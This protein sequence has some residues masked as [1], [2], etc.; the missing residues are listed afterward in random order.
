MSHRDRSRHGHSLIAK[1][2]DEIEGLARADATCGR[3]MTV[4]GIGPIIASAMVAATG[5]GAAFERARLCRMAWSSTEADVDRR[6]NNSWPHHK[7]RKSLSTHALHSRRPLGSAPS[8]EMAKHGFGPWLTATARRLH[9]NVLTVA[10]A[11]K[12][13]PHRFDRLGARTQLMKRALE[14]RF[15][16]SNGMRPSKQPHFADQRRKGATEQFHGI[17]MV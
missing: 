14:G 12:L 5:N 2:T 3:L 11:N 10:L 4:P 6:S 15:Q 1:V 7:A 13:G 8:D 16:N 9:C 17:S